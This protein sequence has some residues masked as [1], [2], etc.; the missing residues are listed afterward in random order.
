MEEKD[1]DD[2]VTK[3]KPKKKKGKEQTLDVKNGNL[4]AQGKF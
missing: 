1:K 3:L 4:G 2:K